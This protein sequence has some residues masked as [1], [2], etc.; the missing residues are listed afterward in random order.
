MLPILMECKFQYQG[1][2][3]IYMEELLS[4][5]GSQPVRGFF[6]DEE[7]QESILIDDLAPEVAIISNQAP[8]GGTSTMVVVKWADKVEESG[9]NIYSPL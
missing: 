9:Y 3:D 8:D 1:K 5:R 6:S 2:L 4:P 7:K